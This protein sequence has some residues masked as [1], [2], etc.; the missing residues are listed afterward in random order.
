MKSKAARPTLND[1]ISMRDQALE[2]VRTSGKRLKALTGSLFE[3]PKQQGHFDGIL[4]NFDR[5]MAI[6]DGIMLGTKIVSRIR[7][8]IRKR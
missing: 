6:Y 2:D 1:I 4:N 5:F 3:P 7:H 8:I